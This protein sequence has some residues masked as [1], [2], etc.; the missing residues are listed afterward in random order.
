MIS[1]TVSTWLLYFY[2]PPLD[3][4]RTQYLSV[5]L[6]GVLLTVGRLWDAVIDP[7]IGYWSDVNQ[8][9]WGRRRPFLMFATP[10]TVISLLLLWTPPA[11]SS[12]LLNG[13]YFLLVTTAFYTSLSLVSIPYDSSL[14]DMAAKPTDYITLSMW[15]NVFGTTGVLVGALLAAPLFSRAGPPAMA[16]VVGGIGLVTIWLTLAGLRERD[17]SLAQPSALWESLQNTFKNRQFLRLL[18]STLLI[19]V[20][21]AMLLANLPYF[22]TLVVGKSEADLSVYQGVVVLTM[23][24]SAPWWS[25]LSRR[26]SNR[27]LLRLTMLG[28]ALVC[29]LTFTVGILPGVPVMAQ[30]LLMLALLGPLLGGYFILVFAMMANVVDYDELL[31][32]RRREATY[33]GAF[34]LAAGIGPSLAALLLPFIFERYGYTASNPLGVQVVFLVTGLLALLATVAFIGYRLG[35]TPEEIQQLLS[36]KRR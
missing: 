16:L 6:V 20:A 22:V 34:S 11:P 32:H 7:L 24:V 31:T 23:V 5:T 19:Y 27:L 26:H 4:G 9:R 28:L 13:L 2:A 8:S 35:D 17:Y 1:I 29:S 15:K 18:V 14:P 30:A 10:A 21:Y 25:W 3:S 33:Y 12:G 36:S